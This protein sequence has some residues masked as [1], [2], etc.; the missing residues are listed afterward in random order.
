MKRVLISSCGDDNACR[1]AAFCEE[2]F[3][4]AYFCFADPAFAS[5]H[6]RAALATFLKA[7]YAVPVTFRE[8]TEFSSD[9]LFFLFDE[10]TKD[11]DAVFDLTDADPRFVMAATEYRVR[12]ERHALRLYENGGLTAAEFISLCGGRVMCV[13]GDGHYDFSDP[14]FQQEILRMWQATRD[15]PSDWNRFCSLPFE[16]IRGDFHRVCRSLFRPDDSKVAERV[17]RALRKQGIV[18]ESAVEKTKATYTIGG[19]AKTKELYEKGGTSLELFV[20]LA[21][22][23]CGSFSDAQTGVQIDLDGAITNAPSDPHNEID[24]LAMYRGRPVFISCKNTRPTREFLYE[25]KTVALSAGGKRAVPA[26]V[27]TV[28]ALPAVAERARDMG[29]LLIDDLHT[30]SLKSLKNLLTGFFPNEE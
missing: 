2:T 4:A 16:R 26:I 6:E 14:S 3:D 18:T 29:V 30:A 13:S 15:I 8:V 1:A 20:C 27:S 19:A 28:P 25:I 21:A 12:R 11:A 5:E 7:K 24:V 17:L 22:A 23:K 9:R 10:W